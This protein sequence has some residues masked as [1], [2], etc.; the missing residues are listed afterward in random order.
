MLPAVVLFGIGLAVCV[1]PLTATA[2]GAAPA[3]HS[4]IASAV[5]N[6]VARAV[7]LI[8]VAVLPLLSGLTGPDAL[9]ASDLAG[10]FRT[11]MFI[12]GGVAA[13]GGLVAALTIRN[14]ARTAGRGGR[15]GDRVLLHAPVRRRSAPRAAPRRRLG[16]LSALTQAHVRAG[17]RCAKVGLCPAPGPRPRPSLARLPWAR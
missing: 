16:Q 11:A 1:A 9:G 17:G 5:N 14:P 15:T 10:G 6:T 8:A 2:M 13:V 4:G 12:S 3:E 7:G